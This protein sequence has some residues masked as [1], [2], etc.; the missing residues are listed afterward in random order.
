MSQRGKDKG[1]HKDGM[2]IT[3]GESEADE[4]RAVYLVRG[5][6]LSLSFVEPNTRDRP[7]TR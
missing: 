2:S 7:K 1:N 4:F 6:V 3:N 5:A